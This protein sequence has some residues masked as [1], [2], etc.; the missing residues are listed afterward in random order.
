LF[1]KI[2]LTVLQIASLLMLRICDILVHRV[3]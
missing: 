1:K 3:W 2:A